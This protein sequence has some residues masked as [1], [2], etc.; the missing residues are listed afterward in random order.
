LPLGLCETTSTL[1]RSFGEA[2]LGWHTRKASLGA[3]WTTLD[4]PTITLS[5]WMGPN[6]LSVG[7][8]RIG[9]RHQDRACLIASRW[10]S[11]PLTQM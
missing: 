8:P 11:S 7:V 3:L 9:T 1:Q 2:P 6:A 10:L 5:G 4:V